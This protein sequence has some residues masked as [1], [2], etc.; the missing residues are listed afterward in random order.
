MIE[1]RVPDFKYYAYITE[2]DILKTSTSYH[3]SGAASNVRTR[4]TTL[5]IEHKPPFTCHILERTE[6]L[7]IL[8]FV[9]AV[10]MLL[11][12]SKL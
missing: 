7:G 2:F 10:S 1:A 11:N 4:R 5:A 9:V 6:V 12:P 3:D 8:L